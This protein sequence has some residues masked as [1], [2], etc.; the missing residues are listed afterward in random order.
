M[1]AE[2]GAA[3]MAIVDDV[4][5]VDG[6]V[7]IADRE[8]R[9]LGAWGDR[10]ALDRASVQNL[11]PLFIW[12]EETIGT[13]GVGTALE[14]T[15]GLTPSQVSRFEH[16]CEPLHEWSCA[17]ATVRDPLIGEPIGV[18][19]ISIPDRP[20]PPAAPGWLERAA[21]GVERQL[22]KR[23]ARSHDALARAVP[24]RPPEPRS[25]RV[26]DRLVGARGDRMIVIPVRAVRYIEIAD[27]SIWLDTDDGRLRAA[28]R[29]LG[30][31][32]RRLARH[33]FMR[34]NR[35]TLVNLR[36]TRELAPSF[37]G[38]LWLLVDGSDTAITVSRRR[39][40]ELRSR[41]GL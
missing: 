9:I 21:R 11:D 1:A 24:N 32:E 28:A 3:A 40:P 7:A 29:T 34:V 13:T 2:L 36:R 5:A 37:K 14:A 19:D 12:R 10:G 38:G 6:L 15:G 17:A 8:G 30:E 4:R 16:W 22:W 27:R 18:I 26:D 33:G 31:L 41:L 25:T 20:L 39:L 35:H 23:A